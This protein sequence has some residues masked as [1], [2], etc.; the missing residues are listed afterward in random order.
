MHTTYHWNRGELAALQS[1]IGSDGTGDMQC[2]CC[3][4]WIGEHDVDVEFCSPSL[5]RY[6]AV[7]RP[8]RVDLLLIVAEDRLR[9]AAQRRAYP[10]STAL[11]LSQYGWVLRLQ[12]DPA[13]Q[14]RRC[15]ELAAPVR[16]QVAA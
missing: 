5:R 3:G 9:F 6:K 2:K 16:L 8:V 12:P 11:H 14:L 13:A 10:R 1:H 7:R 15:D 4:R